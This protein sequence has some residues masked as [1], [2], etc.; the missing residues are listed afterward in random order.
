MPKHIIEK[1]EKQYLA[2]SVSKISCTCQMIN[3]ENKFVVLQ[4]Y[5]F[6]FSPFHCYYLFLF[7][8]R[9][10]T[11]Q[12]QVLRTNKSHFK[13]GTDAPTLLT[14]VCFVCFLQ[15]HQSHISALHLLC[16]TDNTASPKAW[17]PKPPITACSDLEATCQQQGGSPGPCSH[18]HNL[19]LHPSISV[20]LAEACTQ[21]IQPA[22]FTEIYSHFLLPG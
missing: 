10:K 2:Y 17:P 11:A 7:S 9:A 20:M 18:A 16:A 1:Y 21:P 22:K 4:C 15:Y 8:C 6:L 12:Y 19:F 3:A 14:L 5:L 13:K